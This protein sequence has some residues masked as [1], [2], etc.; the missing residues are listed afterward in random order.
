[1]L[2][3]LG[4]GQEEHGDH[5]SI[6]DKKVD[7]GFIIDSSGSVK[8][9]FKRQLE[10]VRFIHGELSRRIEKLRV[11]VMTFSD[12]VIYYRRLVS[13]RKSYFDF[14][15]GRMVFQGKIT[16][17][18]RALDHVLKE[19]FLVHQ[20]HRPGA[21]KVAIMLTDGQQTRTG[22][23]EVGD[24]SETARHIREDGV[25]LIVIG[26]VN[27]NNEVLQQIDAGM[28]HILYAG[29]LQKD[30]DG[31][32]DTIPYK[33]KKLICEIGTYNVSIRIRFQLK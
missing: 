24:L 33:C 18:D 17:I 7:L 19:F 31:I 28:N 9:H 3:N 21:T 12:D 15:L 32:V 26:I 13:Y 22:V 20:G 25:H 1:M 8:Y 10:L 11:G 6:C 30:N 14:Y 4:N 5:H 23:Q 2:P 27:V 16:R 29:T